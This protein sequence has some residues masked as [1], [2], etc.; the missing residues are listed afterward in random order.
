MQAPPPSLWR[1]L[2]QFG[3]VKQ[4]RARN[5]QVSAAVRL[6]K[7]LLSEKGELSGAR[8]ATALAAHYDLM[9]ESQLVSFFSALVM[10]FDAPVAELSAAARAYLED[11]NPATSSRLAK[12]SEPPRQELIRRLNMAPGG[13]ARILHMREQVLN[14]LKAHPE[15]APL[16][17]DLRHLLASWFNRGF[18]QMRQIDWRTPAFVLEKLIKYE[19]VHQIGDWDDLRRRVQ[20]DRRCYGF[21]HPALPDEPLIFVE[22]ALTRAMNDAIGP[23]LAQEM[24]Q[25]AD[26]PKAAIF[27]SISNCQSGLRGIQFGNMLIKQV[28]ADIKAEAPSV[29]TFATLSPIPG[30]RAWLDKAIANGDVAD[31]ELAEKLAT[32]DWKSDRDLCNALR[33]PMLTLCARYLMQLKPDGKVSGITDPVAKFHLSNGARIER[34]NWLADVSAKGMRESWGL[35]VNYRYVP[36][37]IE[38]NHAAFVERGQIVHSRGIRNLVQGRPQSGADKNRLS[39]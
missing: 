2:T 8:H 24:G 13:A 33:G 39:T 32:P 1:R 28:V 25:G 34:V 4:L 9:K 15:F 19:A 16:A 7:V 30:F 38:N 20:G 21:F 3:G 31:A 22:V 37:D 12:I 26:K 10:D 18:L 27:Y 11:P 23:L 17:E 29:S 14:L 6:A 36:N 35:M 5:S